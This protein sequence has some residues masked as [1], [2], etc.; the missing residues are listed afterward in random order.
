MYAVVLLTCVFLPSQDRVNWVVKKNCILTL[1]NRIVLYP[2]FKDI[3]QM[4]YMFHKS[5]SFPDRS[6]FFSSLQVNHISIQIAWI[7]CTLAF[8]LCHSLKTIVH[9][10]I[11]LGFNFLLSVSFF[12]RSQAPVSGS[13]NEHYLREQKHSTFQERPDLLISLSSLT[14]YFNQN[15]FKRWYNNTVQ[16]AHISNAKQLNI[17]KRTLI[18]ELETLVDFQLLLSLWPWETYL[19]RLH[20]CFFISTGWKQYWCTW[21]VNAKIIF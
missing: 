19:T 10:F 8:P 20:L 9:I 4:I 21:L 12:C 11:P 2:C 3:T 5:C 17:S 6:L 16:G 1:P 14:L 18:L 7:I 13:T 15:I